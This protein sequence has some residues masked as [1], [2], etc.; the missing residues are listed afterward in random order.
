MK[1]IVIL[2]GGFAGIQ[3]AIELQK[4]GMFNVTL[5]SDRDFLYIYPVSIWV[6]VH[7]AEFED[8]KVPLA[9]IR[10][11]YPFEVI[12]EPVTEIHSEDH[13]V[14]YNGQKI[15]YDYLIVAFGADKMKHKGIENTLSICGKPQIALSIRDG[16]DQL[17]AQGKGRIAVGFGGNP[18]DLSAVRGGPAFEL[19]FNIHHMLTRKKIRQNFDLTFFAPMAEPGAKMGRSSLAMLNKM[20]DRYKIEKRFGKKISGFED[21]SIV[22]EDGSALNTDLILFIPASAGNS[23]LQTSG[24]PLTDAGF[25]EI[26]NHCK[27]RGRE[28]IYAIGDI[29]ALEGPEWVAKQGHIAELMGRNAAF[30]IIA[31]E[32]GSAKKKGYQEKLNILCVM[33]TG[34]GAAFV[35]RN[36]TRS[37]IIPMPVVGHWMKKGWGAYSKMTKIGR[38]PR[39]PGL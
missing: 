39:L 12:V 31:T 6:P 4:S 35:F 37:F 5:V 24:L 14:I 10:K 32:R 1:K 20:L 13:H 25:I 27:V 3:A 2:G 23:I 34:N 36:N 11:K 29:A 16:L 30:N 15:T 18:R 7:A 28:D 33:D 38:F 17:V 22:F 26:D 9:D 21:K 8:V 19:M